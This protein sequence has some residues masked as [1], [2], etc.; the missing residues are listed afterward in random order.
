VEQIEIPAGEWTF[1]GLADGPETG[2]LVLLLHGFPQTSRCWRHQLAALGAAGYRA[3]AFDQRGYSPGARPDEV[4]LYETSHLVADVL[5]VADW[6]GGHTFHL[7]GHDWGAAIAWQ[8]AG[9]Y[10]HRLRT[11]TSL[12]VPHP[13]ALTKSMRGE[14]GSNQSDRSSYIQLFRAEGSEDQML[15]DDAAGLR[16]IYLLSGMAED[17]AEAYLRFFQSDPGALKGA[18][19][20]Y[21]AA[22]LT[23]IEGLQPIETPTLYIWSTEDPALGPEA[24][25]ATED[26]VAGPYTFE[27]LHG[28]SHWMQ[29]QA[30]DDVNALL[31]EHLRS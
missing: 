25:H 11:M 16:N 14:D 13:L 22:S 1:R 10:G 15:A 7:V 2:E 24:A 6:L 30:P 9:R 20:W 26:H 18:L 27:V 21:R 31:L 28:V 5:A 12:S 4:A 3:V 29:E 19:N 23:L 8:V 17:D